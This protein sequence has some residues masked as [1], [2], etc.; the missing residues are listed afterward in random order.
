MTVLYFESG[1]DDDADIHFIPLKE[2]ASPPR[3]LL[4]VLAQ[5]AS[6]KY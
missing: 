3:L 1:G 5:V 6:D 4:D 2:L